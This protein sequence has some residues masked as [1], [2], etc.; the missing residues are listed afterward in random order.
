MAHPMVSHLWE[1]HNGRRQD[2]LMRI[3]STHLTS[4]ERQ[5]QESCNILK[6]MTKQEEFL[7][8]KSEWGG[9][10]LPGLDVLTPKG[11]VK[12]DFGNEKEQQEAEEEAARIMK[13]ANKKGQKRIRYL[14]DD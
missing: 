11:V 8:R 7:N 6:A 13:E 4:L 9:A 2:V 12:E 3:I 10:K 5:V 1:E 14:G